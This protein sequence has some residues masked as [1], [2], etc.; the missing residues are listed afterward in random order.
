M[1]AFLLTIYFCLLVY[2]TTG[3]LFVTLYH[4]VLWVRLTT[5]AVATVGFAGIVALAVATVGS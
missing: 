5:L 3:S 1:T 4:T 2:L